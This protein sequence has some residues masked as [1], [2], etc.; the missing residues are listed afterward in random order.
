MM[1]MYN[2]LKIECIHAPTT[3]LKC[4]HD[5]V[6]GEFVKRKQIKN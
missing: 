6:S 3:M 5:N 4:N 2:I 1:K